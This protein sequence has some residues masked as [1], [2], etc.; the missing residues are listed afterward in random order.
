[1]HGPCLQQSTHR[2]PVHRFND[3]FPWGGGT[4]LNISTAIHVLPSISGGGSIPNVLSILWRE[5]NYCSFPIPFQMIRSIL[6]RIHENRAPFGGRKRGRRQSDIMKW[7]IHFA[8]KRVAEVNPF[9][10]QM[11]EWLVRWVRKMMTRTVNPALCHK[12]LLP[13]TSNFFILA[14]GSAFS[15]LPD[16]DGNICW[17]PPAPADARGRYQS[18][19]GKWGGFGIYMD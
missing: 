5:I 2:A 18:L 9:M 13:P 17:W 1:M 12:F 11:L 19:I 16:N 8:V 4:D 10:L 7:K 6:E 15:A 3:S 14:D